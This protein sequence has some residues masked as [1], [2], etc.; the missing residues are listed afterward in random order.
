MMRT[1][2]NQKYR[3]SLSR[4]PCVGPSRSGHPALGKLCDVIIASLLPAAITPKKG[5]CTRSHTPKCTTCSIASYSAGSGTASFPVPRVTLIQRPARACR[6]KG[7]YRMTSSASSFRCVPPSYPLLLIL[8][9]AHS[10]A[11]PFRTHKRRSGPWNTCLS[12]CHVLCPYAC[13]WGAR[14]FFCITPS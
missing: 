6:A 2:P 13:I 3:N 4:L 12:T 10:N 5:R 7:K 11:L 1:K 8:G 9:F 14:H